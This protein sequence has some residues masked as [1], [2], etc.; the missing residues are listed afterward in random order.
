MVPWGCVFILLIPVH[1]RMCAYMLTHAHK[2][3][4]YEL[5]SDACI[6]QGPLDHLGIL[7]TLQNVLLP[8]L[9][10]HNR[11]LCCFRLQSAASCP[12]LRPSSH[13]AGVFCRHDCHVPEVKN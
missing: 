11:A 3:T 2:T 12:V 13:V 10:R 9:F 1:L 6:M 5:D 4:S 8:H 7:E